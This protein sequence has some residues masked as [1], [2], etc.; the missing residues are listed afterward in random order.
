MTTLYA[1][2]GRRRDVGTNPLMHRSNFSFFSMNPSHFLHENAA[3]AER[4][5]S[6][7]VFEQLVRPGPVPDASFKCIYL[8]ICLSPSPAS[9]YTGDEQAVASEQT[10]TKKSR[11]GSGPGRRITERRLYVCNLVDASD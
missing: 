4:A 11:E 10:P 8:F 7:L 3:L 9:L 2:A 6:L 1:S 5:H